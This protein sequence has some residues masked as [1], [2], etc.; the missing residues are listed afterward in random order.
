M[1]LQ[2]CNLLSAMNDEDLRM[3]CQMTL[4]N[5]SSCLLMP[6]ILPTALVTIKEVSDSVLCFAG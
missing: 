3:E 6:D 4:T 1:G 2:I 5:M